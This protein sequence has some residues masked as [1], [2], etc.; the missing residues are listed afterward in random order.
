MEKKISNHSKKLS[1]ADD[2]AGALLVEL[3][4]GTTGRNFDIES[5]FLERLDTGE[6]R[7]VIYEFLK[8]EAVSPRISNPNFYW[9]KNSRKFLSLWA[10]VTTLRKAGYLADLLL[11]N[12]ADDRSLGI[13][14]MLVQSID[15]NPTEVFKEAYEWSGNSRPRIMRYVKSLDHDMSFEEFKA[16]FRKFNDEKKGDTWQILS[17]N[18]STKNEYETLAKRVLAAVDDSGLITPKIEA[19]KHKDSITDAPQ[20]GESQS[21]KNSLHCEDPECGKSITKGVAEYS[22]NNFSGKIFCMKCQENLRTKKY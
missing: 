17:D 8:A 14:E 4:D 13:K 7:W 10:L 3:L 15:T 18:H 21:N 6:W 9:H 2:S 12:Y 20:S 16:R 5:I 11:V 19:I 22:R 1:H